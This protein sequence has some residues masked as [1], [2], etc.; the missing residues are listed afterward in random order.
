LAVALQHYSIE[1]TRRSGVPVDYVRAADAGPRLD[2]EV[3]TTLYRVV[4]EAL[5]NVL[6]HA[7]ASRVSLVLE[8]DR[9]AVRLVV[10]DNGVGF[11]AAALAGGA[12]RERLGLAGMQ[13]RVALV[14]GTLELESA[15]GR[16]TAIFVRVPLPPAAEPDAP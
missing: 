9:A 5:T 16:G 8:Q 10:E 11:A 4:Q 6:R 3:E 1:W 2:R 14:H 13:E 15:P 12:I 7:G